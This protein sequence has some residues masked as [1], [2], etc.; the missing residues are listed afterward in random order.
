MS[1]ISELIS[2][3]DAVCG[4]ECD[5]ILR[6]FAES[7]GK[8]YREQQIKLC[9]LTASALDEQRRRLEKE[10]SARRKT[11]AALCAAVGGMIFIALL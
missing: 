1:N 11:V 4:E 6:D 5:R 7:F 10:Y 9:E 2:E 3:C 8:S